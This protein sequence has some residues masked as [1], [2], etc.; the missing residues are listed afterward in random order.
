[1]YKNS[2]GLDFRQLN[3]AALLAT[4]KKAK[5]VAGEVG[6]AEETICQW[7]KRKEFKECLSSL[8]KE[9]LIIVLD[10]LRLLQGTAIKTLSEV[11]LNGQS[12]AVRVKAALGCLQIGKLID[13]DNLLWSTALS[14]E[15]NSF[16][17]E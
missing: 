6:V 16:L 7:R 8:K 3:A 17:D 9:Q 14:P 15:P 4:G 11:M 13:G 2:A 10:G 12:E 5:E 1:M